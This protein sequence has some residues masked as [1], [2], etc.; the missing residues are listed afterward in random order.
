MREILKPVYIPDDNPNEVGHVEIHG[1]N[2]DD[3]AGLG[4]FAGYDPTA[5]QVL[6]LCRERGMTDDE[7]RLVWYGTEIF[8][9]G[10]VDDVFAASPREEDKSLRREMGV[11]FMD[12]ITRSSDRY[13]QAMHARNFPS[14]ST[15]SEGAD[16]TADQANAGYEVAASLRERLTADAAARCKALHLTPDQTTVVLEM[17]VNAAEKAANHTN[18]DTPYVVAERIDRHAMDAL[19][20]ELRTDESEGNNRLNHESGGD[21]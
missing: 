7:F 5:D 18:I 20:D 1:F 17:V 15:S 19:F 13:S 21:Q 12:V 9:S 6:A 11:S 4:D 3:P 16:R 2:A 10:L 8:H 14:V